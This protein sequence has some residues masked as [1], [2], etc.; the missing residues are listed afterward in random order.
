MAGIRVEERARP[1]GAANRAL[2][3]CPNVRTT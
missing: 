3:V 1:G 2:A